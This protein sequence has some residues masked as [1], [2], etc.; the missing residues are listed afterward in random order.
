MSALTT[1]FQYISNLA[2]PVIILIF[3]VVGYK[4]KLK[5]YE[6]FLGGA[7]EGFNVAV[8][9]IPPLVGIFLAI[10]IFR[11]SGAMDVFRAIVKPFTD[12]IRMPGDLMPLA[13]MRPLSGG[14]ALGITSEIIATHGAD[15]LQGFMA[16]VMQGSTDTTFYIIAVYFGSVGIT[17]QRHAIA[18]GLFADACGLLMA[19]FISNAVMSFM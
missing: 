5:M 9:I 1:I 14:G 16:S 3:L 4:K 18:A 8:R 19:V 17:K 7:K 6:L 11:F 13:L 12:L 15:S 2:I 10:S